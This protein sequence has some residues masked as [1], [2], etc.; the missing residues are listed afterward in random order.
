MPKNFL[1]QIR[2][3]KGLRQTDL[4]RKTGLFK[5]NISDFEK[6]K[7]GF[8]KE[9]LDKIA[10]A[11]GVSVNSIMTGE[12]DESFDEKA[13]GRLEKAMTL[14]E[15]CSELGKSTT[16]KV[17]AEIYSLLDILDSFSNEVDKKKFLDS[18]ESRYIA[19]LAAHCIVNSEKNAA[20]K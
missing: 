14:A 18:L 11:L 17:A 7:Q 3:E 16:I 4:A 20:K 9:S 19:G 5:Q 15:I 8:S 2:Q 12:S 10:L 1:K 6:G 13:R